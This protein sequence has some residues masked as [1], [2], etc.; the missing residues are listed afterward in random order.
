M[1]P[2]RFLARSLRHRIGITERIMWQMLRRRR[3]DGAKF[4][5][6]HPIGPFVVDFVCLDARLVIELDGEQHADQVEHDARRTHYLQ[7]LGYAVLRFPN[8][9]V[10]NAI[11]GVVDEIALQL[12]KRSG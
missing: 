5:R 2:T 10:L 8:H 3:V 11:E 9:R 12:V 6:Q 1:D 7:S 4:R